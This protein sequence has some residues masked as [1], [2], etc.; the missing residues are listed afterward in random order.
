[1]ETIKQKADDFPAH[2]KQH[3]QMMKDRE[4]SER[5]QRELDKSLCKVR[6]KIHGYPNIV[7]ETSHSYIYDMVY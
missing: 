7:W 3:L 1:L 4:E 6:M 2:I 5:R